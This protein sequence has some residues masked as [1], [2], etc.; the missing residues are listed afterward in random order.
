MAQRFQ[1]SLRNVLV[2]M[3]WFSLWA[4]LGASRSYL[5]APP[6]SKVLGILLWVALCTLFFGLPVVAV[7]ALFG[8]TARGLR[9][10]AL[11]AAVLLI[12]A[13]ILGA[14]TAFP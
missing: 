14:F 12:L 3:I 11:I 2:A 1:F 8:R 7:C 5:G 9:I 13:V 6:E 4:V 10:T